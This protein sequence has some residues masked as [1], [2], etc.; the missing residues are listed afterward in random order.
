MRELL[1][2]ISNA[3]NLNSHDFVVQNYELATETHKMTMGLVMGHCN[4]LLYNERIGHEN[5]HDM[6]EFLSSLKDC[7]CANFRF[8]DYKNL[9]YTNLRQ[10]WNIVEDLRRL[11]L[12]SPASLQNSPF[13][14]LPSRAAD[15][16]QGEGSSRQ[17]DAP[18]QQER[19]NLYMSPS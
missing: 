11:L 17:L 12:H 6:R 1:T 9:A 13:L 18:M 8:V 14:R 2:L 4:S 10:L 19:D 7:A 5:I 3:S 16:E 15:A